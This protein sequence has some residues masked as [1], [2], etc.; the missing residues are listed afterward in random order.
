V[1][2]SVN[3]MSPSAEMESPATETI[4]ARLT[5]EIPAALATIA[6]NGPA[7]TAC[8]AKHTR[9][10]FARLDIGRIR[11]ATWFCLGQQNSAGEQVV[12]CRTAEQRVEVHCHGGN[13][14]CRAI[15]RDL[16]SMGCTI[17]SADDWPSQ[18]ICP[19]AR[20]AE[21]DLLRTTTDRTAAVLVD[22]MSG[23]LSRAL[24]EVLE[25]LESQ[26][27]AVA[28]SRLQTLLEWS[29]FGLHLAEPW[30]VVL[31]GPPNVGKSSLLNA[32]IGR[33][34]AIVHAEPG[35]TRDWIASATAIEGWPFAL[36]DTAGVRISGDAI[37]TEGVDRGLDQLR[38]AD[39]SVIVVDAAIG[40]TDVHDQ[41]WSLSPRRKLI[42]W[43]KSDTAQAVVSAT[44][45]PAEATTPI[46]TSAIGKPPGFSRLLEAIHVELV[47]RV[48]AAGAAVPFRA[49]QVRHL[50]LAW[51]HLQG[52]QSGDAMAELREMLS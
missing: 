15:L 42:A 39:L 3:Q 34:Q 14:V 23:N 9:L 32:I 27:F 50:Q 18:W 44:P 43:N 16:A 49:Q 37:E 4:A 10:S 45:M 46:P 33:Q 35:T 19:I 30:R 7:A 38:S 25:Q 11:F 17:V 2:H 26:Q 41:L 51:Q 29:D 1:I 36:T 6:V 52:G 47:P 28:S 5:A 13:A 40:W 31:A 48:P 20:A 8:V 22:Q 24:R 21:Q 12:V